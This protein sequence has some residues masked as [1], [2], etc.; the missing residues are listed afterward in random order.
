MISLNLKTEIFNVVITTASNKKVNLDEMPAKSETKINGGATTGMM[1][2]ETMN[3]VIVPLN[4]VEMGLTV[5]I[6]IEEGVIGRQLK[7]KL[8]KTER[9]LIERRHLDLETKEKNGIEVLW[10]TET[11]IIG[12]MVEILG[13]ETKA[14]TLLI[15]E[16]VNVQDTIMLF[17]QE[18]IPFLLRQN[19][20]KVLKDGPNLL[21][22]E[23]KEVEGRG[24]RSVSCPLMH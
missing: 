17:F 1:T 19:K 9:D 21:L 2:A 16:G 24:Q 6:E 20:I 10:G 15:G 3:V 4:S 13:I 14:L 12:M 11:E 8:R 5:L 22:Q 23:G 18:Q 7:K